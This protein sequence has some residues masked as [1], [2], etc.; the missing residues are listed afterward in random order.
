[1][2]ARVLIVEDEMVMALEIREILEAKDFEIIGEAES[3]EEAVPLA[4]RERPDLILMDIVLSGGMDGIEAAERIRRE[5]DT[6]IVFLTGY[7]DEALVERAALVEPEGYILKP[8]VAEEIVASLVIALKK[9]ERA[10][11]R[12]GTVNGEAPFPGAE[13][14][15]SGPPEALDENRPTSGDPKRVV[16]LT[17]IE[18]HIVDL[19]KKGFSSAEIAFELDLAP[20]TVAWHRKNIRTK[21]GLVGEGRGLKTFI[22]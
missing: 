2:R 7:G 13:G 5:L 10:R 1:M 6:P 8:L 14:P 15:S 4:L 11:N 9:R 3:G 12:S 20:T 19:I 16:T 22:Q 17:P 21:F 18:T